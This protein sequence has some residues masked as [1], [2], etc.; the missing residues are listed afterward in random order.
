MYKFTDSEI[1]SFTTGMIKVRDELAKPDLDMILAP[2]MGAVPLVDALNVIDSGF[3]N[4]NVYYVPASSS[5]ESVDPII[6]RTLANILREKVYV[7]ALT[8]KNYSI[9]SLD[10]V[11][12]GGSAIRVT[13]NVHN[14]I[15]SFAD[16]TASELMRKAK[17]GDSTCKDYFGVDASLN[18]PTK[19]VPPIHKKISNE[20]FKKFDYKSIGIEH[21]LFAKS[22]KHRQGTY[23]QL[24]NENKVIPIEVERIITMDNPDLCPV[25]YIARNDVP[26]KN[27][28]TIK[29]NYL[30]N[31][32]YLQ[33]LAMIAA[34]AGNNADVSPKNLAKIKEHQKYVPKEYHAPEQSLQTQV[35]LNV[36][37]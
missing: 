30:V 21:G 26:Y 13:R 37:E 12:G 22:G 18:I 11:V 8:D 3:D 1:T 5:I 2:M 15:R 28:P 31:D 7:K 6:A 27:F 10:E 20:I 36:K 17:Q 29:P 4:S 9:R 23:Q 25:Q 33:L 35:T 32:Q 24:V 16:R 19:D 34:K 14:G